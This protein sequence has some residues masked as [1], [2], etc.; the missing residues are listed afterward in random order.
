MLRG[1]G[2][3]PILS[4]SSA[5]DFTVAPDKNSI[6]TCLVNV[7][8]SDYFVLVLSQRYG[9]CLSV[10][11]FA[12]I[13]ATH[14]EY[15]EARKNNI[16]VYVYVRDRLESDYRGWKANK[17]S[18]SLNFPWVNEKNYRLFELLDEH[19]KL[20][21]SQKSNWYQTFRNTIELKSL[22]SRDLRLPAAR[23]SLQRAILEGNIPIIQADISYDQKAQYVQL[24]VNLTNLGKAPAYNVSSRWKNEKADNAPTPVLAPQHS[25][26]RSLVGQPHLGKISF[27]EVLIVEYQ[28]AEGHYITDRF[29]VSATQNG[30]FVRQT[31]EFLDKRY[32]VGVEPPFTIESD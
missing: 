12:D 15:R 29:A 1:I 32:R 23:S 8:S 13:S 14:L 20:N 10:A 27:S 22:V 24:K 9:P 2:L 31:L 4:D 7:K 28:T 18:S 3:T 26:D 21:I 11:G 19:Q 5:S 30:T 25:F 6:E 17:K 16:P